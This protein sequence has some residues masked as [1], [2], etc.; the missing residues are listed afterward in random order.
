MAEGS[1]P[2]PNNQPDGNLFTRLKSKIDPNLQQPI[3][4]IFGL[5]VVLLVYRLIFGKITFSLGTTSHVI[6]LTIKR[7]SSRRYLLSQRNNIRVF[8]IY[9]D[10]SSFGC[11][12]CIDALYERESI[13][14]VQ[15]TERF[16]NRNNLLL[17]YIKSTKQFEH[18]FHRRKFLE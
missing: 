3:A 2:P 11:Y 10:D 12:E 18:W 17:M 7:T 9:D 6:C 14:Y 1:T 8:S 16:V 15:K 5:V 13:N 4:H